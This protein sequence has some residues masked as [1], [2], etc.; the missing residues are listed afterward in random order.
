M[1]TKTFTTKP[2]QF[3]PPDKTTAGEHNEDKLAENTDANITPTERELLN[4]AGGEQEQ[5]DINAAHAQ[6]DN[7]D[8]DGEALNEGIDMSGEDLDVPGSEQDDDDELIGEEDEENNS[9]SSADQGD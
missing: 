7:V 2:D 3:S 8:E 5:D 9:Y 4:T 6:L 1:T